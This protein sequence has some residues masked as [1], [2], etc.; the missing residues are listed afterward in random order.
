MV[1]LKMSSS[2][3]LS[4]L[5]LGPRDVFRGRALLRGLG[6]QHLTVGSGRVAVSEMEIPNVFENLVCGWVVVQSVNATEPW[7]YLRRRQPP[8]EPG[9]RL[10]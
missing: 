6:P 3:R 2:H 10:V 5:D 8:D 7:C 9:R 1:V 4:R